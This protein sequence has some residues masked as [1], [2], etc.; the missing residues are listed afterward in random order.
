MEK[1]EEA[2]QTPKAALTSSP[3]LRN[4]DFNHPF[5]VQT[6]AFKNEEDPVICTSHKSVPAEQCY[7]TIQREAVVIKWALEE[8]KYYLVGWQFITGHWLFQWLKKTA[9]SLTGFFLSRAI[10]SRCGTE[11]EP[12]IQ[13]CIFSSI[14]TQLAW[15]WG[16][17][18]V[19]S[20][21]KCF[22]PDCR[23]EASQKPLL[24][25]QHSRQLTPPKQRGGAVKSSMAGSHLGSTLQQTGARIKEMPGALQK[26]MSHFPH[27]NPCVTLLHTLHYIHPLPCMQIPHRGAAPDSVS[28]PQLGNIEHHGLILP[29]PG[30]SDFLL[31]PLPGCC[32]YLLLEEIPSPCLRN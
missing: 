22:L 8:L 25:L 17:R 6:D 27:T 21:S 4:P 5:L 28:L 20:I 9:R 32:L 30:H 15:S 14:A 23:G 26:V 7:T 12:N 3:V 29:A 24:P 1:I 19:S 31:A 18:T 10:R 16:V 2:F 11:Q 13:M